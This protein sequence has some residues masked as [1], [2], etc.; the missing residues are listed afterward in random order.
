ML[1]D[2]YRKLRAIIDITGKARA[3]IDR[4]RKALLERYLPSAMRAMARAEKELILADPDTRSDIDDINE[5]DEEEIP[6]VDLTGE[7]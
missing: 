6:Y 5:N 2:R 4:A 3:D 1:E 7:E